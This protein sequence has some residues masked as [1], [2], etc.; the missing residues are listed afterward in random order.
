M[1]QNAIQLC[2]THIW[3]ELP[4]CLNKFKLRRKNW[5]CYKSVSAHTYY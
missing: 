2:M 5:Y 3:A 1:V 4:A